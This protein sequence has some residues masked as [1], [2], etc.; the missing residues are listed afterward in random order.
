MLLTLNSE[1]RKYGTRPPGRFRLSQTSMN[2]LYYDL[3]SGV[4]LPVK[5]FFVIKR[6]YIE[7]RSTSEN[8]IIDNE[9]CIVFSFSKEPWE[10]VAIMRCTKSTN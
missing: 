3:F 2:I 10:N 4:N 6:L 9:H 7:R 5:Q 1:A 8:C